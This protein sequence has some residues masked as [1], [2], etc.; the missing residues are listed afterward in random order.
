MR[1][2]TS[3][4][5]FGWRLRGAAIS[6]LADR[7]K[8]LS[9]PVR[10]QS[11]LDDYCD[12]VATLTACLQ[13]GA[14]TASC[15]LTDEGSL[16]PRR[17]VTFV[18]LGLEARLVRDPAI[19]HCY[20]CSDCSTRCPSGARPGNIMAALRRIA[21]ERFA[22]PRFLARAIND[23]RLFW[24]TYAAAA[25]VLFALIRFAGSLFPA[26]R[27][28]RYAAMLPHMP[29]NLLFFG[30]AALALVAMGLGIREAY[31]AFDEA[32]PRSVR[33]KPFA[34]A[35]GRA[36]ADV[37]LHRGFAGC[38]LRSAPNL[39]HKAVF[40]GTAGL[41]A[42]SAV[43]AIALLSGSAYPFGF[44]SPVKIAANAF[45]A[46]LIAGALYGITKRA[47]EAVRG[48]GSSFFDW[49]FLVNL[50]LIGLSGVSLEALRAA[51][52]DAAYPV[53]FA[54]LVLVLVLLMTLPYSKL[55]HAAYRFVAIVDRHRT[56]APPTAAEL[57]AREPGP[58][59][60]G[61]TEA[62]RRNAPPKPADSASV[63]APENFLAM[64][65]EGLAGYGDATLAAAY[66]KLR[67]E[68]EPRF[69]SRYYPNLKRL[70]GTPFER[71]KDRREARGL[72][73]QPDKPEVQ[74]WYED[75]ARRTCTWWLENHL[76][77]RHSLKS[78]MFCGMCT[79]VCPAAQYYEE[80]NPR[81][82]VDT[83]LSGDEDRLI[84]L[85]RSDVLWFCG[86]CGSCKARCTRE[87]NIMGLV[88]SLR[89]LSQLK[90]Y[91]TSS[92]RGRQQYAG[93]HLWGANFWNRA[94]SLYFRNNDAAGHPDFGP[95]NARYLEE[96]EAQ[97][98]RVGGHPD[99]DGRFG[100]RKVSPATLRELR[101]CVHV[102]GTLYL[103]DRLE[104]HA[105]N[106][107]EALGLGI[108][109]YFEKVRT[110]G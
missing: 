99:T 38:E 15:G 12:D 77:A 11:F 26:E 1:S 107:A 86:Q 58:R 69:G 85:L 34:V 35:F 29:L 40:F 53:Y 48:E 50:A 90:G 5:D 25:A 97:A 76:V 24:L 55:A 44:A 105:G 27:A 64:G 63:A 78:C 61:R 101:R 56:S 4:P 2:K 14:C 89:C 41:L 71:E 72:V 21:I 31:R 43:A 73:G 52:L 79:S 84:A 59:R 20:G 46:L 83:A 33:K 42:A 88:S 32:G 36:L 30:V 10:I 18:Q 87:N 109:E 67:D 108:D 49:V 17:E 9:R 98:A 16:F 37:V 66:Y 110:E 82:I 106:Q 81:Y 62:K 91:H 93:R 39:A 102:G 3:H 60:P 19:W 7:S 74:A 57:A 103:W 22:F 95:R 92:V 23:P 8:D 96:Q 6:V 65:H 54:H 100:G 104:E 94:C 75:A 70:H 45:A 68:S 51:N 47:A 80:Y 13:C 28:V